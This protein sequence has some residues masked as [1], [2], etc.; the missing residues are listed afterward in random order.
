M[1][2]VSGSITNNTNI[3]QKL[4]LATVSNKEYW[5]GTCV[6]IKSFLKHN[7]WFNGDIIII[8][9]DKE[10]FKRKIDKAKI[11][12]RLI[13]PSERL[14]NQIKKT[15]SEIHEL[16][17][18]ELFKIEL[19]GLTGYD[20]IIYYDSDI[21]HISEIDTEAT[22][23]KDLLATLDPW[24]FRGFKRDKDTLTKIKSSGVFKN[25][26]NN[27]VNSGFLLIGKKFINIEVYSKLIEAVNPALYK[28]IDDILAD[29][30]VFNKV[31]EDLFEIAPIAAN[32]PVH[33]I[34]E[35]IVDSEI[36]ALHFTGK[37]KPWKIKTWIVLPFRKFIY[38]RFLM[39]W[40]FAYLR[41]Y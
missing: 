38:F 5:P 9:C 13:A 16:K 21:L 10:F 20:T 8:T 24:H 39:K 14:L 34:A 36:G 3:Q 30:P 22:L 29:E 18:D 35:G 6:M 26:Y 23:N 27:Y 33:L 31:F 15:R 32:C 40:L 2:N 11:K 12:A 28:P 37:N 17:I 7:R 1:K 19:F 25:T 41:L 4:C